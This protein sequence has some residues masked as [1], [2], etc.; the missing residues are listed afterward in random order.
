MKNLCEYKK[1]KTVLTDNNLKWFANTKTVYHALEVLEA[2]GIKITPLHQVKKSD[3]AKLK[4]KGL[5]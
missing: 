1:K 2:K 4:K 3:I 5:L